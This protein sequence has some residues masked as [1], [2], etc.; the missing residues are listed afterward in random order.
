M[1]SKGR[2]V[3]G[4]DGRDSAFRMNID[5]RYKQIK[6]KKDLL[7]KLYYV[8]TLFYLCT[9]AVAF[10]TYQE[11]GYPHM[12]WLIFLGAL[13]PLLGRY[14][15]GRNHVL[16]MSAFSF[17][18]S[19]ALAYILYAGIGRVLT[20]AS[21]NGYTDYLIAVIA[22]GIYGV[23]GHAMYALTARQLVSLMDVRKNKATK[24]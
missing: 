9:A 16:T 11:L 18:S 3:A 15:S 6:A 22:L 12:N 24:Q 20:V 19:C 23:C 8:N 13:L 17:A 4:V 21:I 10:V 7:E 14:A 2:H 1:A 5:D